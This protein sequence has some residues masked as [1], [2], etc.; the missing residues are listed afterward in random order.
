[1]TLVDYEF[2]INTYGGNVVT[3][4]SFSFWLY[5]ANNMLNRI[6]YGHIVDDGG[7]GSYG[8]M[9]KGKFMAF[10]EQELKA[11]QYSVCALIDEMY[12][13]EK[14]KKQAVEGNENTGNIKSRSSGGESISYESK[15]TVYDDALKDNGR[16]LKLYREILL[17][18]MPPEVF[19]IN[20]FYAGLR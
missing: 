18:Y 11:V 7:S 15:A 13:L 9:I 2:Y 6:T 8:Q 5:K 3:A 4:E 16:K 1:M 17:E 14:A 10:T 20:P 12:Q 19:R